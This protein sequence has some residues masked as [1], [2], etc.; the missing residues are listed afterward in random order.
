M[1]QVAQDVGHCNMTGVV[2][3]RQAARQKQ[4]DD[5]LV[6]ADILRH[7]EPPK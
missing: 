6:L 3:A 2:H 1:G 4:R 7:R 5:G